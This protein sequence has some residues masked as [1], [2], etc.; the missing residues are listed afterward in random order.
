MVAIP[1][2]PIQALK[3]KMAAST[4]P[5]QQARIQARIAFKQ[6]QNGRQPGNPMIPK[7]PDTAAPATPQPGATFT[8]LG[9]TGYGQGKHGSN[10]YTGQAPF[11]PP[12]GA[13]FTGLGR[14]GYGQGKHGSNPYTGQAPVTPAPTPET[15]IPKVDTT[16]TANAKPT[17]IAT[18]NNADT[19]FPNERMFEPKNY[20]GSPLYQF[21]VKEGLEQ[22][23]KSLAARG[24]MNSGYGIRQ[25]LNVPM[26]AAAQDTDRMTR[27]AEN[28]ANR[29]ENYQNNE[30]LRQERAGN[31]QWDRSYSL[32]Q[33]MAQQSP[34]NQAI[35]GLNNYADTTMNAGMSQADFVRDYYNRIIASGGG[36]GGRGGGGGMPMII[37]PGPDY[38]NIIP[39]QINGSYASNNGWGNIFTGLI[40]S[41]LPSAP[42]KETTAE[43]TPIMY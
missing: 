30:A 9:R 28:N 19:L 21:Q 42:A 23:D 12:E 1:R 11:T 43:K 31:N 39:A 6:A 3:A 10:P 4:D 40:S 26:M 27:V 29:L 18:T 2:R 22:V 36:G 33:L 41:L 16:N 15:K 35:A 7:V 13:K 37:P 34:W 24:L 20:E 14:H 8:G 5:A 38:S 32:A 25:E 17:P